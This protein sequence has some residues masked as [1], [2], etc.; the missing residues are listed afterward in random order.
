MFIDDELNL[1]EKISFVETVHVDKDFKDETVDLL[2][3]EVLIRSDVSDHVPTVRIEA[4]RKLHFSW[5]RPFG[6]LGA[7]LAAAVV[8]L[9]F[10]LA[11]KEMSTRPYR[12]VIYQPDAGRVELT[13]SFTGWNAVPLKK[14]GSSGYWE[15]TLELPSGEHRLCYILEGRERV[16]DPTILSREK[17]DFGGVNSILEV[18]LKT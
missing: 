16:P 14:N 2:H 9:F 3:Q 11:P 8:I 10:S 18:N 7:G 4:K 5:F 1:D 15:T 17:D 6:L 13:G 12:F